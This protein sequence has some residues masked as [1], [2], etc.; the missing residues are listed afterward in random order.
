MKFFLIVVEIFLGGQIGFVVIFFSIYAKR[1]RS[2]AAAA[3]G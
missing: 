2:L 3:G 1:S